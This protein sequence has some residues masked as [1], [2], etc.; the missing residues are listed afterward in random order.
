M[1][2]RKKFMATLVAIA[3]V[4]SLILTA[5]AVGASVIVPLPNDHF[6]GHSMA[7]GY[8]LA[9]TMALDAPQGQVT[10]MVAVGAEAENDRWTLNQAAVQYQL[11]IS[12]T[13]GGSVTTP[14]EGTFTY[15]EGTVVNLAIKA[16]ANYRF[17]NWTGDVATLECQCHSTS[18]IMN[19][20]Y[21]IMANFKKM[22]APAGYCFIATAAYG[23][24]MAKE[25]EILRKFRD[26]YLL[27]NPLGQAFVDFYYEVSPPMAEFITEHPNLKPI[28]RVG[29]LPAV[30]ISAVVV[31]T[32]PADKIAIVG[33]LALASL[34]VAIWMTR[35]RGK[36]PEYT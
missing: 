2:N 5:S 1:N 24:P 23:T 35:R 28:V 17:I 7:D 8:R 13:K 26:E 31:N 32:T 33:L 9:S 29:L 36:G 16:D 19:G 10:P 18:I 15:T 22:P 6:I 34:S 30:A 27:T 11:T 14:G 25:I 20:N 3:V 21:Y 12:S 4:L